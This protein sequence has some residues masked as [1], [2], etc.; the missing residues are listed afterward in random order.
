[1]KY[2]MQLVETIERGGTRFSIVCNNVT[3][4]AQEISDLYRNRW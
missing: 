2:A 1:M 4:P 3:I